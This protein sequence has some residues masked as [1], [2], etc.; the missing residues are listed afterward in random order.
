MAGSGWV[1]LTAHVGLVGLLAG[2]GLDVSALSGKP[3]GGSLVRT[4]DAGALGDAT[5]ATDG[6]AASPIDGGPWDSQPGPVDAPALD[7]A[8]GADGALV[9]AAP[10]LSLTSVTASSPLAG[11]PG[12]TLTLAGAGMASGAT[13]TFAGKTF[14]TVGSGGS[15]TVGPLDLPEVADNYVVVLKNPDGATA[16]SYLVV[17][18]IVPTITSVTASS[19]ALGGHGR[20]GD[21]DGEQLHLGRE[22]IVQGCKLHQ[23][24]RGIPR[25][26]RVVF[27]S[28]NLAHQRARG[29]SLGEQP[30]AYV[31]RRDRYL[32]GALASLV[33]DGIHAV[34]GKCGSQR[35]D[36]EGSWDKLCPRGN[37]RF[38]S[39]IYTI[40]C[41]EPQPQRRRHGAHRRG[42]HLAR[43]P[44]DF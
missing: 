16:S 42:R 10:S 37:P 34:E 24:V 30:I 33:R 26:W 35:R 38:A 15:V 9:D 22:G 12:V 39:G 40:R 41:G 18:N 32:G 6:A 11:A 43:N 20:D 31:G 3:D 27:R 2:C 29:S 19:L 21:G 36:P 8:D 4:E 23:P 1:G 44:R 17:N 28:G 13:V 14:P 7:G 5:M 25:Q